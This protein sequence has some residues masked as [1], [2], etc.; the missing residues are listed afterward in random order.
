G[1]LS[2]AGLERLRRAPGVR[3]IDLDPPGHADLA[4]SVPLINADDVRNLGFTGEGV[5]VAIIDSGVDTDHPDLADDIVGQA[6]F[7]STGG[8]CCPNG[9][10]IQVGPGAAEDQLGHGTHVAGIITARGVVSARGV[11]PDASLVVVKIMAA[12]NNFCCMSDVVAGLDWILDNHPEVKAINMSIGTFALYPGDCDSATADTLAL[13]DAINA[14]RAH[15]TACFVSSGNEASGSAMSSPGCIAAALSVGSVY[16]ANVG[17]VGTADCTDAT[18]F[19]DK[20]SC[21]SNSDAQT[22]IFAPGGAITAPY[23]G[24]GTA[25]LFGTSMSSPHGAG[26]AAILYQAV[27][28]L[29]PATLEQNLEVTGHPVVDAKNGFTFPRIDCL[30]ALQRMQSCV[31]ADGDGAGAPGV[32]TCPR[33]AVNDCDD[34]NPQAYPGRTEVCDGQD[35]D[36]NGIVDDAALPDADGDGRGDCY[37]NCPALPNPGQQNADGD[38]HGDACDACPL[39]AAD[40]VDGDGRCANLDVCPLIAD[41]QQA[42]G[43]HDGQGDFCDPNDGVRHLR[44][45]TPATLVWDVEAGDQRFDLYRGLLKSL[46]DSD[47]NGAADA[48]GGCA[49]T[50]LASPQYADPSVPPLGDGFIYIVTGLTGASEEGFGAASSGAVR[51]MPPACGSSWAHAP[52]FGATILGG[53]AASVQCDFTAAWNYALLVDAGIDVRVTPGPLFVGG[54]YTEIRMEAVVTDNDASLPATDVANVR[55]DYT[56]NPGG[57]SGTLQLLDDGSVPTA[58]MVQQADVRESCTGAPVPSEC[59]TASY[60]IGSGDAPAADARFTRRVAAI[61]LATVGSGAPFLADCIGRDRAVQILS[62]VP[63]GAVLGASFAATDR[64]GTTAAG[65]AQ[66]TA[67][68]AASTFACSGDPCLCCYL[69]FGVVDGPCHGLAGLVGPG[70]PAGL[71]Q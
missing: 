71:C 58:L 34:A 52:V 60:P 6:C 20:V 61:N 41:P 31:D 1:E 64:A 44:W 16:D 49:A 38:A 3:R 13:A 11:A 21:F 45:S 36:C 25:T 57:L 66:P 17:G 9:T 50:D 33:G 35:N 70:A 19:A 4:Q 30:A 56:A 15:G 69:R 39:D 28:T 37:D 7:C 26:C 51:P 8:A 18:T 63:V 40:D 22:D 10:D 47:Q 43:D 12:S 2:A 14:L 53:T 5:T 54:A 67:T 65:P 48:Y 27:P 68:V 32:P 23:L 46:H 59:L 24:G 29:T 62:G 42:D 55:A